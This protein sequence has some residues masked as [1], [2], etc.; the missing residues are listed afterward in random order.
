MT[1]ST[2]KRWSE[3]AEKVA[4]LE[5]QLERARRRLEALTQQPGAGDKEECPPTLAVE[6]TL[7]G[8]L[9]RLPMIAWVKDAEGRYVYANAAA[10]ERFALPMEAWRGRRDEDLGVTPSEAATLRRHDRHVLKTG[11]VAAVVERASTRLAADHPFL[12]IKFPVPLR[13][14]EAD[15][16]RSGSTTPRMGAAGMAVEVADWFSE[17][18]SLAAALGAAGGG[19]WSWSISEAGDDRVKLSDACRRMLGLTPGSA[20]FTGRAWTERIHPADRPRFSAAVERCHSGVAEAYREVLRVGTRTKGFRHLLT[21]GQVQSRDAGGRVSRFV[22][23]LLDVQPLKELELELQDR[24]NQLA[25]RLTRQGH[26]LAESEARFERLAEEASILL[27]TAA[28]DGGTQGSG[29]EETLWLNAKLAAFFGP[30]GDEPQS[31]RRVLREQVARLASRGS[32]QPAATVAEEQDAEREVLDAAGRRRWILVRGHARKTSDG[33][34]L[35]L[36]GTVEDVTDRREARAAVL[37]TQSLLEAQVAERT[38]ELRTRVSELAERNAELDRFTHIASHDLRSPIQTIQSFTELV[39]SSLPPG[40]TGAAHLRRVLRAG[41]RMAAL[42]DALLVFAS[43]GRGAMR[44]ERVDLRA[45]VEEAMEDLAGEIRGVN[46]EL[47][48]EDLPIVEGA[49]GMHLPP[50]A[51]GAAG[52]PSRFSGLWLAA[53]LRCPE[54]VGAVA[55]RVRRDASAAWGPRHR[56]TRLRAALLAAGQFQGEACPQ[57]PLGQP[58]RPHPPAVPLDHP[59]HDREADT[60]PGR[61]RRPPHEGF[62]EPSRHGLVEAR[63]PVRHVHPHPIGQPLRRHRHTWRSPVGELEGVAQQVLEDL[64]QE[65]RVTV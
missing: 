8:V 55:P 16:N 18:Q 65:D 54:R 6:P 46:L 59:V 13:L 61:P 42:L 1:S 24:N 41:R 32:G 28:T 27:W 39:A 20:P 25:G 37:Q 4:R 26:N 49:T 19:S 10:A 3:A 60:G 23:I 30:G 11:G 22:G 40:S 63:A 33:R 53:P 15:P 36:V 45:V 52:G 34:V 47:K 29:P 5:G 43:V 50:C 2:S 51:C 17:Q 56:H 62:E 14:R 35:E 7:V 58:L 64:L 57:V 12:V 44:V 38:E 21:S 9:G 31:G 48:V